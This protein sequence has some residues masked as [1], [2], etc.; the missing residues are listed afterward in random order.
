M[1]TVFILCDTVNRRMLEMYGNQD[2]AITPNLSRLAKQ[3]VVFDNHWCGSAPCMPARKDLM[4][5]RMDFLEKPWGAMEPF[6]QTLQDI[7]AKEV[8][9]HSMMFSDHS[10]YLIP[11]GENY[12]K[13][14]TA[15]EV[16]RGQEGDPWCV[17][18]DKTGMRPECPPP[19]YKGV[20][21]E[22]EQANRDRLKTEC[23][24]PSVK[25]M[26]H[27]SEWL[28][29]NHEADNFFLWVETFDPH[30]P[31]DVPKHYLD[32]YEKDYRGADYTHPD[33]QPNIFTQEET[34]HLR[35]C[36]KALLT[37]TDRHIG[38]ILTVLDKHDMWKDTMVIF[39]TDHGFHLGEHGLMAK[40]YMAPY[41]EVFHIPLI[42]C[43]PG[44]KPGRCKAVTQ[45]IDIMP[46]L[47]EYYGVPENVLQYPI[48]GKSILPL[49]RNEMKAVREGAI[50][51][52]YGKQ[53]GYT[54]GKYTY[55]R[56]AKNETNRPLCLYTAVPSILRQY[57]GAND[58]VYTVDYENIEMGRSL[59]W[60]DYPVYCFPADII[61]FSNA[62][63][64]FSKR[65][66]FNAENLLF[67]IKEDY[68]QQNQLQDK[69]LEEKL[70]AK[71]RACMIAHDSP[72][73]QFERLGI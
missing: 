34:E 2:T 29:E 20:Y 17:K 33:Y 49:L 25:S 3:G 62:S 66:P 67:H 28:E 22:S 8:N 51:G 48:H 58:A 73:E 38:D 59:S 32:M 11:G 42:V 7:L 5:G 63:Q 71:L 10:H 31:Y 16:F 41:N 27:A 68:L 6:N 64:E 35:N 56:A 37:M 43:H 53:V 21:S 55:F 54:D 44:I 69:E 65:S 13:G 72:R 26:Y 23:D 60:L 19:G 39:T 36:H 47:M 24:Y 1:K 9:V 40:N 46:T 50:F 14:F 52:Y 45:N 70:I 12:L 15:W 18:P 61:H 30:E 57:L 4:T